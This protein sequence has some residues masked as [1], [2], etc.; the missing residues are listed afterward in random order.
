[1]WRLVGA[2]IGFF[3][4]GLPGAIVGYLFGW[5]FQKSGLSRSAMS[6]PFA[7]LSGKREQYFETAFR[8]MGHVAKADGRISEEEIALA[9]QL[10]DQMGLSAE[11]KRSAIDLF[12]QGAE[13]SFSVQSE[14]D[15]FVASC[16]QRSALANMLLVTLIST[17]F[18]DASID[19]AE[20]RTLAEV[21][22]RLGFSQQ[23]FEQLLGMVAAQRGFSGG[24]GGTAENQQ[25]ALD[26]AYAALGASSSDDD[27]TLK[28]AYRK[29]I[30]KHHPDKLIAQGLPED[31]IAVATAKSQEI[32]SAYDMIEKYRK[33]NPNNA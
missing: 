11:K 3:I 9:Q 30:S 17:A 13:S 1:M 24:A 25:A 20:Q 19:E 28:R 16:G 27:K 26:A 31:M 2:L 5:I 6:G 15:N 4:A 23:Q 7:N 33:S 12:K 32:Q 10:M 18:A 21:A 8:L 22:Q 14:L 29:L